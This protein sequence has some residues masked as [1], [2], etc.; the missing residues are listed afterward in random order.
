MRYAEV[1]P[2]P[3]LGHAIKLGWTLELDGD[4]DAR[5]RHN[6]TPDGCVELIRRL[7]GR[8][9]W[10]GEQPESFVAGLITAPAELELSGDGRF[11]GIRLWPWAWNAIGAI[12]APQLIDRWSDLGRAAPG[13][14]LPGD[15][16]VAV[17]MLA[18]ALSDVR[19]SSLYA[20]VLQS[21]SVAELAERSGRPR[22]WLQRW[23]KDNIGVSPRTYLRLLRF[24]ET[25]DDLQAAGSL[26]GHAAEHGFAD[27]AHMSREFRSM[28]GS[29]ASAARKTAVG[30]FL[31]NPETQ[32]SPS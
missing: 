4:P 28:A 13:L 7:R 19:Q 14:E 1:Q 6:A 8:S 11:V 27:Q 17:E 30:P 25:F 16:A 9:F 18:K 21:R 10:R 3:S 29:S 23:F 24:S 15:G 12:R 32:A 2:P 5:V 22:R 31:G 26:A 20:A